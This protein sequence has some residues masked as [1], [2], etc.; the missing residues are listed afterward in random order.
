MRPCG[1]FG[2]REM[3]EYLGILHLQLTIYSLDDSKID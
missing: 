1:L 3:T 2:K